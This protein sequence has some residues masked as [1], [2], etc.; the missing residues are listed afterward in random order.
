MNEEVLKAVYS[1]MSGLPQY[2]TCNLCERHR[3]FEKHPFI[4]LFLNA[5]LMGVCPECFDRLEH[6]EPLK[7][8]D[9]TIGFR[10]RK[11]TL[12]ELQDGDAVSEVRI[13]GGTVARKD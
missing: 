3:S 9:N 10:S 7:N 1:L 6:P 8:K 5:H 4:P 2:Y 12:L 13:D 11:Q